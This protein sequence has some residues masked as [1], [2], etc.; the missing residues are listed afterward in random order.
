MAATTKRPGVYIWTSWITGLLSSDK[1]CRWA[2]WYKSRHKYEKIPDPTFDEAAW[3][4]G[5]QSLLNARA[6]E[7]IIEDYAVTVEGQNKIDLKGRS[8]AK[9]AGCPDIEAVKPGRILVVDA[10]TGKK[11]NSDYFQVLIYLLILKM[12]GRI[13]DG[14]VYYSDGRPSIAINHAE[15][16]PERIAAILGLL[17]VLSSDT[18]PPHA[19]SAGECKFCDIKDC[20]QRVVEQPTREAATV[21]EF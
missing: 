17:A 4:A 16:T 20:D 7:L 19:P 21:G 15:L 13:A 10:K 18:A 12:D 11:R 9:L 3:S 14:E 6:A 8:G 5:H 2:A 1:Q